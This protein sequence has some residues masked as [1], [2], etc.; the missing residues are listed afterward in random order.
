MKSW[1]IVFDWKRLKLYPATYKAIA[2][3]ELKACWSYCEKEG[4][5]NI[6]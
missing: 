1:S 6:D 5:A 2:D 4:K 3:K